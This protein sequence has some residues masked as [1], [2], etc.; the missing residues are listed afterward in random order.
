MIV[1]RTL[2]RAVLCTLAM[3]LGLLALVSSPALAAP[4][5]SGPASVVGTRVPTGCGDVDLS[6]TDELE[7]AARAV[8]EVFVAKVVGVGGARTS[9]QKKNFLPEAQSSPS[10]PGV[11]EDGGEVVHH[12]IVTRPLAGDLVKGDPARIE[13][14][15][16]GGESATQLR[17]Q[18]TYLLFATGDG[19]TLQ[20]DACAGWVQVSARDSLALKRLKSALSEPPPTPRPEVN[21]T[22]S[23]SVDRDGPDLG[24]LVAPGGALALIGVLGLVLISRIG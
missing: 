23:T 1:P 14:I 16:S 22:A 21:M 24:R 17:V 12:V 3:L 15:A 2:L 6:D 20:A 10:Q 18:G 8:D 9:D 11:P 19:S 4:N 7:A 5:E 13:L